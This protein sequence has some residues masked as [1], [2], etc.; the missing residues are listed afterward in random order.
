MR[1]KIKFT[2]IKSL[3]S[4]NI[5]LEKIKLNPADLIKNTKDKIEDYY[6]TL[7]KE[8]DKEKKRLEKKNHDETADLT[9]I[10]YFSGINIK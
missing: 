4:K 2:K 3:I 5:G 9:V 7:K 10:V 8:R 1:K 6:T